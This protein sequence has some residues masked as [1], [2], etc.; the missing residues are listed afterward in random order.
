MDRDEPGRESRSAE[1]RRT[2]R[3]RLETR[4]ASLREALAAGDFEGDFRL[5]LELE[6]YGWTARDDSLPPP[7]SL[8]TTQ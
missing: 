8:D 2:F 4:A 5:G 3:R 6:G 7:T 1:T